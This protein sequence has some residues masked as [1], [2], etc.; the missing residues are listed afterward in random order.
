MVA[1]LFP[2]N[3]Q[4]IIHQLPLF[5]YN[6]PNFFSFFRWCTHPDHNNPTQKNTVGHGD[7]NSASVKVK[8][9]HTSP[10]DHK[11]VYVITEGNWLGLTWFTHGQPVLAIL[12]QE[13]GL[14]PWFSLA[15][16]CLTS[17]YFHRPCPFEGG[18]SL[19]ALDS[20]PDHHSISMV[21]ESTSHGHWPALSAFILSA[22]CQLWSLKH[23]AVFSRGMRCAVLPLSTA[24]GLR[25]SAFSGAGICCSKFGYCCSGTRVLGMHFPFFLLCYRR[26]CQPI[27]EI[28]YELLQCC[29][30]LGRAKMWDMVTS[31]G[32]LWSSCWLKG[33]NYSEILHYPNGF[34]VL[35]DF[36]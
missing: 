3:K 34:Q 1:L 27:E 7:K 30:A 18:Y 31:F 28:L 29:F 35:L 21:L 6:Y 23:L 10:H 32:E 25:Y 17:L 2:V 14:L 22:A 33:S 20:F 13:T 26:D 19:C 15:L 16:N 4:W 8:D 12:C 11:Y 24:G 36:K 5:E 9:I